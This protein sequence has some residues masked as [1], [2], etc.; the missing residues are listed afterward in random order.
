MIRRLAGVVGALFVLLFGAVS[1]DAV[2]MPGPRLALMRITESRPEL[3]TTDPAGLNQQDVVAND[4]AVEPF[5]L[6][7]PSWSPDGEKLAVIGVPKEGKFRFDVYVLD[8]GDGRMS[9]VPGTRSGMHPLLSP[10]GHT[11]AFTRTKPGKEGRD[12]TGPTEFAVWLADLN[13]GVVRRISPYKGHVSDIASSFSPDGSKLALTRTVGG[14]APRAVSF[15]LSRGRATVL[16]R[17]ASEPVYSPDGFRIA[18][19]RMKLATVAKDRASKRLFSDL[20]VMGAGGSNITRLTQTARRTES[21]PSWDPSGQR[22]SFL[23]SEDPAWLTIAP[24][25]GGALEEINADGTCRTQIPA[26][27]SG[28]FGAVWQP[29]AGREAGPISC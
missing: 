8:V 27:G 12:R 11:V 25:S 14:G 2:E 19:R 18:F 9:L 1:A 15:D 28:I 7:P 17:R 29:G 6:V 26:A 4:A 13:G 16:A 10:D 20:Y 3:V 23:V 24:V 5:F 22:L 21:Q